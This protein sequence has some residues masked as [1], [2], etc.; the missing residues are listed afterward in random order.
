MMEGLVFQP[1]GEEFRV[2]WYGDGGFCVQF[3]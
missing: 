2:R 1:F 3:V